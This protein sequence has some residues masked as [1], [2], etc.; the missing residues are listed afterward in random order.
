LL[1]VDFPRGRL[2]GLWKLPIGQPDAAAPLRPS[3]GAQVGGRVSPD[4]RRVLY[5]RRMNAARDGEPPERELWM[6]DFPSGESPRF[7]ARGGIDP[8][9]PSNRDVSFFD[10]AGRFTLLRG[11]QFAAV[12]PETFTVG[13]NTPEA[14]RNNY[15]WMPDGSRVLV[16]RPVGD[17]NHVRVMVVMDGYQAARP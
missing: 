13:V 15:A 14:S 2:H 4:G 17:P 8:S 11:L 12:T 9:W 7:V 16:N 6:S 3:E 1:F 10:R 5:V